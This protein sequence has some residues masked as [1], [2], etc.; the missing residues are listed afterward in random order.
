MIIWQL[1]PA[2]LTPYYDMALSDA[3]AQTGAKLRFISSH[4]L[5]EDLEYPA[6]Y[7]V[8]ERYFRGLDHSILRKNA[9]LRQILRGISYPFGHWNVLQAARREKPDILH[10]QWSRLPVFDLW[11]MQQI[12]SLG[13][14]IV[15]T[16]H[17]VIPIF[18][19]MDNRG[20]GEVYAAADALI[21]HSQA[22]AKALLDA[23]PSLAPEK[24]HQIPMIAFPDPSHLPMP[25]GATQV[26]A[27]QLL[28]IDEAAKVVLFFGAMKAY[29]GLDILAQAINDEAEYWLVGAPDADSQAI[30]SRLS[31]RKNV[32]IMA[33][34]VPA[35]EVWRYHLAADLV[36]FPYRH[37]F[38][39]AALITALSYGKAVIVTDVGAMPETID[40]NGWIIPPEDSAAL[41]RALH[42]ALSDRERL[43]QMGETSRQL[44]LRD[45]APAVVA[46]KHITLYRSLL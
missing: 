32:H 40:G 23:Y 11:L 31:G 6:S 45:Y 39:S 1:D 43:A 42:D 26:D 19:R 22:N 25:K 13:I 15:H 8:D 41:A 20:L 18:S 29:K 35:N 3:L 2:N 16:V 14:P 46:Q 17:D 30:L 9:S 27:R 21:V 44:I 38:Q 34:Y 24:I 10:I 5:Y 7:Q 33:D 4:Y 36:I 28:G 12:K 37:I